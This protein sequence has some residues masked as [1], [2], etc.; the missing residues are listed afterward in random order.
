ME[1]PRTPQ[2]IPKTIEDFA[3]YLSLTEDPWKIK[4][5]WKSTNFSVKTLSAKGE[6][7]FHKK[8]AETLKNINW[9][10]LQ[11]PKK[12]AETKLK[13]DESITS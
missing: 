8:P 1:K 12:P 10:K 13:F 4:E 5:A 6:Y 9:M 2:W 3:P 7:E 11:S